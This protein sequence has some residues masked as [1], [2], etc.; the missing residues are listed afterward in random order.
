MKNINSDLFEPYGKLVTISIGDKKFKV[1]ENNSILR[2]FQFLGVGLSAAK[3]CWNGDCENCQFLF[4]AGDG[5][6]KE[7]LACQQI[8][9]EGMKITRL[10]EGVRINI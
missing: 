2:G 7:A 3:L 1:P 9:F 4:D 10:P 8:A 5:Q 6:E